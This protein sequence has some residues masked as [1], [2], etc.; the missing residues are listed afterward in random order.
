MALEKVTYIDGQTPV[1]AQNLNDIQD[2]VDAL[3]A[4]MPKVHYI[5]GQTPIMAK[6][7]NDIQDAII[8][9]EDSLPEA[10]DS[11]YDAGQKAEYDKFWDAFQ[12]NG[13]RIS[14]DNSFSREGWNDITFNPKYSIII[15]SGTY[16]GDAMFYLSTV[17]DLNGILERNGVTIDFSLAVRLHGIFQQASVTT[18]P[19]IDASSCTSMDRT[20]YN[21]PSLKSLTILNI[22]EDCKF[23]HT[24][25]WAYLTD[26]NITGTIGQNGL[27]IQWCALPVEQ[28]R[29]IISCL[30]DYSTDT[31]GTQWVV[32][33]GAT[34]LAKLTETD[35][36]NIAAKGWNFV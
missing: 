4:E 28:L 30:K 10:Y 18:V 12:E 16:D 3:G 20:F 33:V 5:D 2:A 22:R 15:G 8:E 1:T 14:Y 19:N 31:S 17:T 7:L 32:T 13:N 9:L 6:N 21:V 27:N 36:A 11:G 25:S 23:S 35:L 29:N 26:L 34:N 24:L